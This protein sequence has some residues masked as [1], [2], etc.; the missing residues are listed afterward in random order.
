MLLTL[1]LTSHLRLLNYDTSDYLTIILRG[2][3]MSEMRKV[4]NPFGAPISLLEN[5]IHCTYKEINIL[6]N[7]LTDFSFH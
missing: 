5:F 4:Q 6:M 2:M 7:G 1:L 3:K